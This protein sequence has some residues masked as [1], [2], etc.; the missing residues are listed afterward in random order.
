MRNV[1]LLSLPLVVILAAGCDQAGNELVGPDV[2]LAPERSA[3]EYMIPFRTN[4]Y[5]FHTTVVAPDPDC[6][7]GGRRVYLEGDGTATHLG[8]YT[9]A[10]S[11]CSGAGGILYNGRGAFVA[12]NGDELRFEFHGTS[13]F[14][15]PNS[16]PFTSFAT[17]AGGSGRF[18]D[19]TGEAV[20]TGTVNTTTGGGDGSWD[21]MI[22]SVGSSDE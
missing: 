9:V 6:G 16:L 14:V 7:T 3:A 2:G 15:A 5:S 10:L 21:G 19:A 17:F 22:S 20:V 18:A 4:S 8:R 11:F 13:A 12:A 1:S